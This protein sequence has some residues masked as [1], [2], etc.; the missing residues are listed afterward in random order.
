MRRY[1]T[2]VIVDPDVSE[3]DR[4]SLFDRIK[5]IIPQQ[6]GVLIEEDPWGN[7]K[8]AYE[9]KKKPRGYY[10][11]YDYCGMGPVVDEIER[12]FKIDD[13]VLKYLTVQLAEEA[14]AERILAEMAEEKAAADT[15]PPVTEETPETPEPPPETS[16]APAKAEATEPVT[17]TSEK[18]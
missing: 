10:V 6:E 15:E 5:E 18:E 9:I 1:E 16:E 14:D 17:E 13:R 4:N 8:L 2:I 11:R 3:G 7:K 12:F